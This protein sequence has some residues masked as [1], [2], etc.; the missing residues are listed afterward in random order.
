MSKSSCGESRILTLFAEVLFFSTS[1]QIFVFSFNHPD[2]VCFGTPYFFDM[3]ADDSPFSISF[4]I[5]HFSVIVI[6]LSFLFQP[7]TFDILAYKIKHKFLGDCIYSIFEGLKF[8]IIL[9]RTDKVLVKRSFWPKIP[10]RSVRVTEWS[11]LSRV[12]LKRII[13]A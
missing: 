7:A 4:S 11:D 6:V 5:L 12:R 9:I 8:W 2:N 1:E 13:L 3:D 10:Q